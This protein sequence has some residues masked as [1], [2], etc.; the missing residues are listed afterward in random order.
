MSVNGYKVLSQNG[1]AIAGD[2]VRLCVDKWK[3]SSGNDC[4]VCSCVTGQ[5]SGSVC[6][7]AEEEGVVYLFSA[8]PAVC[9]FPF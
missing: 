7:K 5:T 4:Q 6:E 9:P 2:K 3:V 1:G 8:H